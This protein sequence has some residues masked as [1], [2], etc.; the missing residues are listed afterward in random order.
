MS[1]VNPE[2]QET[3]RLASVAE[4]AP[5]R[6]S[7]ESWA[8]FTQAQSPEEFCASWLLIQCE[9][10]GGVSDG[11]VLLQAPGSNEFA[12]VAFYPE[13]PRDRAHLAEVS[14]RAL[15]EGRGVVLPRELPDLP[16]RYQLGYP[17]RVDGE[18]RGAVGME[19]DWRAEAQLQA[20]MRELQWG[21]GWL[22]VLLRRHADPREAAQL[23]LKL[24][25]DL[26]STLLGQRALRD[27]AAA[28]ATEVATRLGCE[29]VALGILDGRKV[30]LCAVSH[31]AQFDERANL[32]RAIEAAMEESVDQSEMVVSPPSRDNLPVVAH[33]HE[34]LLRES[35]AGSAATFPLVS[36]G[37]VVGALSLERASGYRFDAQTLELGEAL[38]A[39]AGPIVELKRRG[40]EGLLRHSTH[41]AKRLWT[42]L[43]G[44]GYPGWK[45]AAAGSVAAAAFVALATGTFRVSADL[46]IEGS[47]QRAITA[48]FN[49]YVMDAPLRA[50]DIVK[51]GQEIGRFDDRE[52]QLERI[53]LVSQREQLQRQ[54]REAMAKHE[55]AQTEIVGAQLDQTR[56]QLGLVEEQLA[57]TAMVAPMDGVI[58]S[59]DLS[60]MRGTPVE[61]GQ[62]LFELAPLDDYRIVLRVDE[63][64]IGYVVVGQRGELAVT[65]MPGKMFPF[66]V[67]SIV[68]VNLAQE[69][70]NL[71]RVEAR[72]DGDAGRLRPGMSGVGKIHIDERKLAWIWTRTATD[73]V[74]LKLWSLLP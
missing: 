5:R 50:G 3:R 13:A 72:L 6:A 46:T 31:S 63:R 27:S 34:V 23:R 22:E 44:P 9:T 58:V 16:A 55:R 26:V 59:G 66:T 28:F 68:P 41:S 32:L 73:W 37:E 60:Q 52:L 57:R 51:A 17:I 48:P 43:V 24:A 29:R 20:A 54:H 15:K 7:G 14:E 71:F 67:T 49:G 47:V 18:V 10:V 19:M 40:E 38:A 36:D 56:A 25:L 62:V 64:D 33:A 70:R 21:S 35:G 4:L 42:K 11:V 74:R 1:S 45:L 65:A 2:V 30:K 61:R 53:K 39:V 8:R 12:P 69:G